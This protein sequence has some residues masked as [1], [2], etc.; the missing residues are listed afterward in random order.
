M[1]LSVII[2][3]FNTPV[4]WWQRCVRSVLAALGPD[5]EVICVDDGSKSPLERQQLACDTDSR[6]KL[7]TLDK[8]YGQAEARN[9]GLAVAQGKY[10][11]FVDSDDEVMPRIYD[12]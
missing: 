4:A 9:R 12:E 11:T 7:L 2:P 3:G 8:N 10:V 5:D 1:R 6:V